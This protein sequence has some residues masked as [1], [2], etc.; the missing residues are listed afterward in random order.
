MRLMI[1][2]AIGILALTAAT[3]LIIFI[4][5]AVP[6]TDCH[7]DLLL[8]V[9]RGDI[10]ASRDALNK[11]AEVNTR[12]CGRKTLLMI[13]AW[14]GNAEMVRFLLEN[15]ASVNAKDR[16]GATALMFGARA[17]NVEIVRLLLE[18][19]AD[20]NAK[21]NFFQST[22]LMAAVIADNVEMVRL[23]LEDGAD[24]E[25][26]DIDGSTALT[27]AKRLGNASIINLLKK[28]GGRRWGYWS[29]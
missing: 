9:G 14:D 26:K 4:G 18:K 19:G 20:V 16:D 21:D 7:Q 29:F 17:G 11:G 28:K 12:D 22:A 3:I 24:T 10:E 2:Q 13:A 1:R 23:L 6:D 15:N 25:A 5:P 8:A 27:L